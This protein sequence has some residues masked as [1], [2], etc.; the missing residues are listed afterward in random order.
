MD[1]G[2][3]E[4][5]YLTLS[6]D[7]TAEPTPLEFME[8][9]LIRLRSESE[10]N[11]W[12]LVQ[13]LAA[14]GDP[15]LEALMS[16]RLERQGISPTPV[17]GAVHQQLVAAQ[18]PKTQEFVQTHLAQG[19]VPLRSQFNLDYIPLVTLLAQQNYEEAD[20]VTLNKLCEMAGT[21]A[22]KRGWIYFTEVEQFP[23]VD[24]QTIDQ[25]WAIYSAGKFGFS[26]QRELWLR[27]GKNWEKLWS[28]L[29]WKSGNTWTRYPK[30]FTWDLTA[31][32]GHLPLT[33]QLRGVRVMSSLLTHPAWTTQPEV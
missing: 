14:K 8:E 3:T 12:Q 22:S 16:W 9:F 6:Q 25:L 33:N 23:I 11:Q 32:Q 19:V 21:A 30:E 4:P 18:T 5:N 28:L 7:S 26:V 10:K 29:G 15:G 31:P 2:K 27:M 24:L 20:R 17:D 13:D 1:T